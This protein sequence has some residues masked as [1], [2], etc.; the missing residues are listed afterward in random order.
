MHSRFRA[1]FAQTLFPHARFRREEW[2]TQGEPRQ[3]LSIVGLSDSAD[4]QARN[5]PFGHQRRLEIA[6]AL[7]L[8]PKLLLLDEPAASRPMPRS[9]I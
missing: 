1:G 2:A 5:L 3:L 7:A 4:E 9:W 8:H 6:R